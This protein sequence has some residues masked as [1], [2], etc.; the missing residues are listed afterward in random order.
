MDEVFAVIEQF[1]RRRGFSA[2]MLSQTQTAT[3]VAR[4]NTGVGPKDLV[5]LGREF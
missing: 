3:A 4:A 5:K 1:W 2:K